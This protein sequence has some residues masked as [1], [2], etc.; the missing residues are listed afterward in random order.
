M[1]TI[2][3]LSEQLLKNKVNLQELGLSE[4]KEWIYPNSIQEKEGTVLFMGKADGVKSLYVINLGHNS[5]INGFEGE[6]FLDG[7]GKICPLN[8]NNSKYLREL[9]PY[10]APTSHKGQAVTVG[11]GDRLGLA[12]P[13]HLHLA[14]EYDFFP[15]LAQQSIR[16]LNLTGR[17]YEDVLD[18][19]SW[20]VFQEGYKDGF[21]ADGDHLK[22]VQEVQYALD[23]GFT[24]ITLDCSDHIDNGVYELGKKEI[25]KRYLALPEEARK[26]LEGRYLN[27][28]FKIEDDFEISFEEDDFRKIVLIYLETINY[29]TYIYE[30]LLK[31]LNDTVDFEMSIDETL[32]ETSVNSHYF[33]ASELKERGVKV[34]SLAP[35][36]YG[37][38]Q[39]GIDYIGEISRFEESFKQH[40]QIADHFGYKISVHSGSDKFSVF[41]IVGKITKQHVHVKT[42]GTNWLE[43][44]RVIAEKDKS[45]FR[46][47]YEFGANHLKEAKKYYHIQTDVSDII[48]LEDIGDEEIPELLNNDEVRQILHVTY[49]LILQEK[50]EGGKSV[51]KDRIYSLL[52]VYEEDYYKGLYKHIGRHLEGLKV[53]K[54][55]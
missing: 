45:M 2:I 1:N 6:D 12:S 20:A 46:E 55:K 50:G 36:F 9:F 10:T 47:L 44:L 25:N 34:R 27:T 14:K 37:E 42:A 11:L 43:A 52:N 54:K 35:R 33:V 32:Y 24:M 30:S 21:G 38:F 29:T 51:F 16:E 31:K 15:V 19:A 28:S 48:S 40:V 18:A 23:S 3:N 22:T 4:L 49:G 41:P 39:K 26:E 13:G 17:S 7:K 5:I 53:K 8:S